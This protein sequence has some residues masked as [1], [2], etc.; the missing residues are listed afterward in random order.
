MLDRLRIHLIFFMGIHILNYY[1][2]SNNLRPLY[3]EYEL[4]AFKFINGK[5]VANN[6]KRGFHIGHVL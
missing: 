4:H 1:A 3:N 6:Y 2:H 5:K